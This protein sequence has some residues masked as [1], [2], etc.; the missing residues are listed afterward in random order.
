MVVAAAK[1]SAEYFATKD[2]YAHEFGSLSARLNAA[3][4]SA[5]DDGI[6][7]SV[8]ISQNE[9]Y[10]MLDFKILGVQTVAGRILYESLHKNG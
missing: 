5:R 3:L 6:D 7:V 9:T 1:Q 2:R 4:I 10:I 8:E